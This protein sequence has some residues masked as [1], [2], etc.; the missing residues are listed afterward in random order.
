MASRQFSGLIAAVPTPMRADAALN[1]KPIQALA[2]HLANEGADGVYIASTYGEG[3]SLTLEERQRL[4][5]WWAEVI[6]GTPMKLI[7]NVG[8]H[9]LTDAR[10]LATH[11]AKVGAYAIASGAP[12]FFK[13]SNP[14]RLVA[15]CQQIA[16]GGKS[17][18]Y[19]YED[20]PQWTR[21]DLQMTE[22]LGL[23]RKRIPTLAGLFYSNPDLGNFQNCACLYD[24]AFEVVFGHEELLLAGLALGAGAAVGN[25]VTFALPIYRRLTQAFDAEDLESARMEQARVSELVDTLHRYG[26]L[27]AAK[28][29]MPMIG[30]DCGPPRLPLGGLTPSQQ[31]SLRSDLERIEFF[32]WIGPYHVHARKPIAKAESGKSSPGQAFG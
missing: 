31:N 1:L 17:L 12:S 14:E 3:Y 26:T 13:P 9:S 32:D 15:V 23:G 11:A 2:E 4:A 18:P 27:A 21:V 16:A 24:G 6:R 8:H 5:A 30:I 22:F 19:Y 7:V 25:S 28:A 20:Q 29:I 10:D